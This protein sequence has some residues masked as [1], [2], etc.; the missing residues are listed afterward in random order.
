M[1]EALDLTRH[2][3]EMFPG[4]SVTLDERD[5]RIGAHFRA[6]DQGYA[7]Y[8]V[9]ETSRLCMHIIQIRTTYL[10]DP[11]AALAASKTKEEVTARLRW[12]LADQPGKARSI[13]ILTAREGHGG[14]FELHEIGP[15]LYGE[16]AGDEQLAEANALVDKRDHPEAIAELRRLL[17][18]YP[19]HT[20]ALNNLTLS[21]A[22]LGD[23]SAA[24]Q[25]ITQAVD[26]EPNFALYRG[27]QICIALNCPSQRF[28]LNLFQQFRKRYPLV[29]D[30]DRDG[31]DAHLN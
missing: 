24:L 11:A 29:H 26:I 14:S 5:Y 10:S 4:K 16:R 21:Y 20:I 3:P 22:S 19:T 18:R 30:F 17:D 23:H 15:G 28:G 12:S 31:I 8:L 2:T 7:H 13:P 25:A 1:T 27:N 6:G 9:N